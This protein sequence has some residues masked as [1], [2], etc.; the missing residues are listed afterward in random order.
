MVNR[1]LA[2]FVAPFQ[3]VETPDEDMV[4]TNVDVRFSTSGV[5]GHLRLLARMML[6][7][8]PWQ[9]FPSFKTAIAAAFGMAAWVLASSHLDFAGRRRYDFSRNQHRAGEENDDLDQH[10]AECLYDAYLD[11]EVT[12]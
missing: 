3:R 8:R 4:R 12:F 2:E 11:Y 9:L 5:S 10:P 6:A 7:N 1:R